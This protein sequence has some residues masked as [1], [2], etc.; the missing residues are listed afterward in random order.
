MLHKSCPDLMILDMQMPKVDG[1]AVLKQ[2]NDEHIEIPVVVI[3][4]FAT[5]ERA[6]DAMKAGALDFITKPFDPSHLELVV[7]RALE[8]TKLEHQNRFLTEELNARYHFVLGKSKAMMQAYDAM[9]K[10]ANVELAGP[11]MPVGS[12]LVTSVV[13]GDVAAVKAATDAGAEFDTID[14]DQL[15]VRKPWPFPAR[16]SAVF[17]VSTARRRRSR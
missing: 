4:A 11:M 2:L 14:Q 1:L 13:V 3:S 10:A 16:S 6:V 8:R 5:V 7:N 9:L 12:A 17:P 15:Q